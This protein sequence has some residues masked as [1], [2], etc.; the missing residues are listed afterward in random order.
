MKD[1]S[2]VE[3]TQHL[4]QR[5]VAAAPGSAM[6]Q[7]RQEARETLLP[8]DVQSVVEEG[9]H[10][11]IPHQ[12]SKLVP[13]NEAAHGCVRTVPAAHAGWLAIVDVV[14]WAPP[15]HQF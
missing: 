3:A 9:T 13:I 5:A 7:M 1:E 10:Q 11:L 8:C 12:Q 14:P 6:R 15:L 2:V 4:E